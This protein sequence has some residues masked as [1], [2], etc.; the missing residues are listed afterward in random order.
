[1]INAPAFATRPAPYVGMHGTTSGYEGTITAVCEW[2]RT[3]FGVMVEVRVP[4]GACC[5]DYS[6]FVPEAV[7]GTGDRPLI[8]PGE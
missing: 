6:D 3:P 2:S 7:E 5:I 1:M 4:G 8:R